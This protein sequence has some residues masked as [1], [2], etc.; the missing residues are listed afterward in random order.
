MTIWKCNHCGAEHTTCYTICGTCGWVTQRQEVEDK[1][2]KNKM[3]KTM[4]QAAEDK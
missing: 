4:W 3:A 1:P 2:A